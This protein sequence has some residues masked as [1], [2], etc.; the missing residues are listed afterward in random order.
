MKSW[1]ST[2]LDVS[3]TWALIALVTRYLFVENEPEKADVILVPGSPFPEPMERAARLYSGWLRADSGAVG[4][5]LDLSQA[6]GE[7]AVT[8][9]DMMARIAVMLRRS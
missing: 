7:P 5:L 9:C 4:Q 1:T 6:R 3:F 8:E 2:R